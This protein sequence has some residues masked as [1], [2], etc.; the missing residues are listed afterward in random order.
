MAFYFYAKRDPDIMTAGLLY[1]PESQ[2][3][4]VRLDG[5]KT[6]AGRELPPVFEAEKAGVRYVTLHAMST[7]SIWSNW[8]DSFVIRRNTPRERDPNKWM[9]TIEQAHAFCAL[10]H[11]SRSCADSFEYQAVQYIARA[12]R[13]RR[14]VNTRLAHLGERAA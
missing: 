3:D 7:A 11:A 6:V 5:I 8:Y 14:R 12:A 13:R 9:V 2:R 1:L 10:L 4:A